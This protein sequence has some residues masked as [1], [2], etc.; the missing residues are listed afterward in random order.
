[1]STLIENI[2]RICSAKETIKQAIVAKGVSVP[3]E[4]RLDEYA[5]LISKIDSGIDT[6]DATASPSDILNGKTAYINGEKIV[7][8]LSLPEN[9]NDSI[10][11]K[12]FNYYFN[13]AENSEVDT[14][15]IFLKKDT[16]EYRTLLEIELPSSITNIEKRI[17]SCNGGVKAGQ[18]LITKA[19]DI[20]IGEY[21]TFE[22]NPAWYENLNN[23]LMCTIGIERES[24]TTQS[25][26][27]TVPHKFKINTEWTHGKTGIFICTCT[28]SYSYY[29]DLNGSPNSEIIH[30]CSQKNF[31]IV[32]A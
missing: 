19:A 24:I 17:D 8:T 7:G 16:Q 26:V 29:K 22:N 21:G 25:R 1:M 9:I 13:I 10:Y 32:I 20:S 2:N 3:E 15:V 14:E 28:L 23:E 27:I 6:S 12:A 5:E 30:I 18:Y 11:Q 4:T 31:V